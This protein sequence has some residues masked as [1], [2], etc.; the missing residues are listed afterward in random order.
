MVGRLYVMV[1]EVPLVIPKSIS[2]WMHLDLGPAD[3]VAYNLSR[4]LTTIDTTAD[5][6]SSFHRLEPNSFVYAD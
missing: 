6:V 1:G 4:L 5:H 2:I 3:T